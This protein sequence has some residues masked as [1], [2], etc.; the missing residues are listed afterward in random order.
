MSSRTKKSI[1]NLSY[2]I[3]GQFFGLLISLIARIIFVQTLGSEY[4]GVNGLFSNILTV[5]SLV[6]LGAGTALTYSLYRPIAKND[7]EKIKSLM[8]LYKKLYI[9]IGCIIL[10]IGLLL[11]PFYRIFISETPDIPHLDFIFILFVINTA[12]SYFFAYKRIMIICDQNRYIATAYRYALFFFLNLLQILALLLT[13]NY[14]LFLILQI[15]FTIAENLLLSKKANTLYPYLTDKNIR[16]LSKKEINEI[17]KN[18]L[19]MSVHKFG[20]VVVNSTDNILISKY[21]GLASVGIYSNYNLIIMALETITAQFFNAI[22]ASVGNLNASSTKEKT[23]STFKKVF[24]INYIIFAISS[25]CLVILFN[26][27][28]SFW[29][30]DD[31]LLP[32]PVIILIVTC[33]YLKGIRKSCLT[34]KETLGIFEQ[35]KYKPIGEAIINLLSSILLAKLFGISGIFMG[36]I[37][38]TILLPLWIEPYVLYKYG[39]NHSVRKYLL[40]IIILS[41]YTFITGSLIY[42]IL[43][44]IIVNEFIVLLIKTVITVILSIIVA[45]L[46]FYK[47]YYFK[48]LLDTAKTIIYKKGTK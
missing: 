35:D 15:I 33:F 20:G 41:V 48:E 36:T 26:D 25:I 9:I 45:L 29:L 19:A 14:I 44:R 40:I 31:Y 37:L 6:E 30:G 2:A 17:K 38:S 23:Y 27:F 5:L 21:I 3:A 47:T 4:L 43:N 11:I 8:S 1:K 46:P 7:T 16:K 42:L 24:I 12:S 18:T 39:F 13:K 28:I 22:S 10:L 34:F 32:L